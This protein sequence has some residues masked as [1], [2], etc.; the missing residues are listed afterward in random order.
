MRGAGVLA[1]G[2]FVTK[3]FTTISL[4]LAGHDAF[5]LLQALLTSGFFD[6]LL[7]FLALLAERAAKS[8]RAQRIFTMLCGAVAL[9]A[10]LN[11]AI[12]AAVGSPL[13]PN[14]LAYARDAQL[15][16]AGTRPLAM[17]GAALLLFGLGVR[18]LPGWLARQSPR[19]VLAGTVSVMALGLVPALERAD[20]LRVL[21][22]WRSPP[23]ELAGGVLPAPSTPPD[24]VNWQ[25]P[26]GP[27]HHIAAVD[28]P[29]PPRHV[30][31]WLAES[32]GARHVSLYGASPSQTPHLEQMR[33][34]A[35]VVDEAFAP[36]PVS[37]KAIF[38]VLCG[39]YPLPE[40]AF[41]TRRLPRVACP[42]FPEAL[43]THGFASAL[44]HGGYFAFTDKRALFEQ[45][46]FELLLDGENMPG[47]ERY[48]R[49]GWGIDD[50]ALVEAQ[51]A[52]LDAKLASNPDQRT[53][54][55]FIPLLPHYEYFLPPQAPRPFGDDSLVARH[56]N[57][58]FYDDR[59]FGRLIDGFRQRGLFEDTLFV[60]VGDHGEAFDEHPNNRLHGSFLFDENVHAP[61]VFIN[62]RLFAGEERLQRQASHAD[63]LPTVLDL[64]GLAVPDDAAARMQGRSLVSASFTPRAV[65]LMT[66]YP[67][68]LLGLVDGPFKFV[69]SMRT[70][71]E[72][73]FDRSRDPAEKR[74][75]ARLRPDVTAS[76]RARALHFLD[77]QSP[78]LRALPTLGPS[79]TDVLF[80]ALQVSVPT[81]TCTRRGQALVCP[82]GATVQLTTEKAF[83]M[84][85]RCLRAKLG[86]TQ[87]LTLSATDLVR[88]STAGITMTDQSRFSHTGQV[89][90]RFDIGGHITELSVD[91]GFDTSSRQATLPAPASA[92]GTPRANVDVS[93]TVH[94]AQADRA[95]VCI[96]L[97]P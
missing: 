30:V 74:N 69:R 14:M 62:P 32:T 33:D 37:A 97:A 53:F 61:L 1:W 28:H 77:N 8:A 45:R 48:W 7:V 40:A 65:P 51:L 84:E 93:V 10:V 6:G 38:S 75:L 4:A 39:L 5:R 26:T 92:A 47:R 94:S 96:T 12:I 16:A 91:Q 68:A 71:D 15:A 73:L 70:G 49:N 25:T 13:T 44:F 64:L 36:S 46:G 43:A 90:A 56:K 21:A 95:A 52:W 78:F 72:L 82:D 11:V 89:S 50:A 58:V 60:F 67:D 88:P 87:E 85:Q 2:L 20:A 18:W 41:E 80:A 76:M 31:L 79:P 22:L 19:L 29:S 63:I 86:D 24:R 66:F 81:G 35:L 27:T 59:Q 9:Y 54:S 34:S 42:S 83:N 57:G 55:F 3:L 17:L 23:V